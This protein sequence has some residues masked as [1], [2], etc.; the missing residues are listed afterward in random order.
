MENEPINYQ[1]MQRL[2][3]QKLTEQDP[4]RKA[5]LMTTK[6]V[7]YHQV[8]MALRICGVKDDDPAA[9]ELLDFIDTRGFAEFTSKTALDPLSVIA[10]KVQQSQQT[11]DASDLD[12]EGDNKET[13]Q[14]ERTDN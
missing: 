10:G 5:S 2:M 6:G 8:A 12:S 13:V 4:R 3:I 11:I 1:Q 9:I 14:S 7:E